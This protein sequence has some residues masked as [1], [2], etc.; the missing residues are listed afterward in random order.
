MASFYFV[1]HL[2]EVAHTL[3]REA[4]PSFEVS[5]INGPVPHG[6]SGESHDG[7]VK[8]DVLV[9]VFAL[10]DAVGKEGRHLNV[11]VDAGI[12]GDDVFGTIVGEEDAPNIGTQQLLASD[13]GLPDVRYFTADGV[14]EDF[15]VS[16]A[17]DGH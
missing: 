1:N 12:T 5:R 10:V 2:N 15:T 3:D 14:E 11:V 8:L 16:V 9:C 6:A 13:V 7:V 17:E 4:W